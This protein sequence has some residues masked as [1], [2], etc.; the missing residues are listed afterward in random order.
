MNREDILIA[1]A[2]IISNKGYH[3]TSMQSIAQAVNLQKASLYHHVSSKQEILLALLDQGIDLL[4]E[5]LTQALTNPAPS[6]DPGENLARAVSVY[7]QSM[8]EHRELAAVLLLEHRSL[9]PTLQARHL[10]RRDLFEE[11]WVDL[12]QSGVDSNDFAPCDPRMTAK[13][14]LGVM[15]WTIM[16]YRPDGPL[17]PQEIAEQYSGLFL[18]GLRVRQPST[19]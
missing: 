14:L 5:R 3:G 6:R 19:H 11:I 12:I 8:A 1:A 13:A 10:P 17:S 4:T 16:W 2:E 18:N 9:P 7:M 15:N